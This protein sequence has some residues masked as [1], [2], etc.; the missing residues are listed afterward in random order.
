MRIALAVELEGGDG[1]DD[2]GIDRQRRSE[3]RVRAIPARNRSLRRH[4]VDLSVFIDVHDVDPSRGRPVDTVRIVFLEE[5]M[6]RRERR[7]LLDVGARVFFMDPRTGRD[8]EV[9]D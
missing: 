6:A 9:T 4:P 3:R 2:E 5:W 8:V 1:A 7:P